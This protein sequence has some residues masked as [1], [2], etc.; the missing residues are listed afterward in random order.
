MRQIP[1]VGGVE[2][3]GPLPTPLTN[4]GAI[5]TSA[6]DAAG[7]VRPM[8]TIFEGPAG[9]TPVCAGRFGASN[10][11]CDIPIGRTNRVAVECDQGIT[12]TILPP[13]AFDP[14]R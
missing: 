2:L 9:F 6:Q 1:K 10:D 4:Q 12:E 11:G 14:A 7:P 3:L 5:A 13:T 8:H